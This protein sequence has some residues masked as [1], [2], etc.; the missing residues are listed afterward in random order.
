MKKNLLLLLGGVVFLTNC[1]SNSNTETNED[2]VVGTYYWSNDITNSETFVNINS[3]G[4]WKKDIFVNGKKYTETFIDTIGTW[5]KVIVSNNRI[6]DKADYTVIV[7]DDQ[8]WNSYLF[9]NGCIEIT[10]DQVI[11]NSDYMTTDQGVFGKS[12]MPICKEKK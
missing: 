5:K 10:N 7:F 2:F 3:N 4:T 6:K 9:N 12:N 11:T 8:N 1:V